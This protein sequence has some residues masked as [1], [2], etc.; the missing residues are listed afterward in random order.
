[1]AFKRNKEDFICAHCGTSVIGTGYTNHCP[2]CLWSKHVD[3]DPGDRAEACGGMME[4]TAL[5]GT[6]PSYRI[7]H[8][9]VKCGKIRRV[10]VAENDA[11]EALVALSGKRAG[12]S[13]SAGT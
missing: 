12:Q 4:P 2:K 10:D 11:P 5:E 6:T 9:C 13:L 7:V 3:I 8:T 1:M